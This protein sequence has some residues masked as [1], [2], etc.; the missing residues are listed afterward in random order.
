MVSRRGASGSITMSWG[1]GE[2]QYAPFRRRFDGGSICVIGTRKTRTP[3]NDN[4]T[5]KRDS[6]M[7]ER[8]VSGC[9]ASLFNGKQLSQRDIRQRTKNIIF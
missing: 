1:G 4:N 6:V 7:G 2:G 5:A 3:L 9:N 8:D